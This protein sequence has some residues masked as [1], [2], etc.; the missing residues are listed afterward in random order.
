MIKIKIKKAALF[1]GMSFLALLISNAQNNTMLWDEVIVKDQ[2]KSAAFIT[3]EDIDND[4]KKE[5]LMTSLMESGSPSNMSGTKGALRIFRNEGSGLQGPWDE[6]VI[7]STNKSLPFINKPYVFDVNSDGV[8]D[9]VV[10]TGF[11]NTNGGSFQWL[12]GPGYTTLEPFTVSTTKGKTDYFWHECDQTDLDGDG[13]LDIITT[14]SKQVRNG[15]EVRVE[16]FK[17]T[18]NGNYA[19]FIIDESVGGVF[20]KLFD[21]DNDGDKDIVLTNFFTAP[22]DASA[23][24]LENITAPSE[25]NEWKGEWTRHDIDRTTGLGYHFE[26][27]DIDVDGDLE[28]VYGNHNNTDNPDIIDTLGNRIPSGVYWFEFPA[29]VKAVSQW[30]RHTISEGWEINA[31]DFGNPSSQGSPGLI[32]IGDLDGNGLPDLMVPGDGTDHLWVL[33]Q[34]EPGVFVRE[35]VDNGQMYGSALVEDLDS[36]GDLEVLS[37]MHEFPDNF[38]QAIFNPVPYGHIKIYSPAQNQAVP[39][40][41][42]KLKNSGESVWDM[43]TS[44]KVVVWPN[45]SESWLYVNTGNAVQTENLSLFNISGQKFNVQITDFDG[46]STYKLNLSGLPAGM[47]ILNAGYAGGYAK[48][49]VK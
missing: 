13:M 38:F 42:N 18:S 20:I 17:Q 12:A 33:L 14:S 29:D 49:I 15:Y 1:L 4:G 9:I 47:Y 39:Y 37:T 2:T 30:E 36:D 23:L 3:V 22:E 5:I 34:T 41:D 11:L 46:E 35:K 25:A 40:A 28:M 21:M 44:T 24:W 16:W 10:G 27:Y 6:T 43:Q 7:I 45:P 48:I 31:Y 19:H 32:A 8:K 26:F